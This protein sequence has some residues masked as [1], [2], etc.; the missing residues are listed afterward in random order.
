MKSFAAK[1]LFR[2]ALAM[3]TLGAVLFWNVDFLKIVFLGEHSTT[4]SLIL[5]G[6][7]LILFLSGMLKIVSALLHYRAQERQ[8]ELFLRIKEEGN[9]KALEELSHS[10][11][12]YRRYAKVKQLHERRTPI[13]H[14]AISSVT[15]AEE[16]LYVSYPRFV[17]NIL[18][19]TGVFGTIISLI[20]ALAGASS[21]LKTSVAGQGMWMI[22]NGMNTA[23]TTTG[24][25]IVC[26]FFFTYFYQKLLDAQTLLFSRIEDVTLTHIVPEFSFDAETVNYKIENMVTRVMELLKAFGESAQME[27]RAPMELAEI[28]ERLMRLDEMVELGRRQ[29]ELTAAMIE[30]SE[31]LHKTMRRGFR[32]ED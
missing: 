19:L 31:E 3:A 27:Q 32:L 28:K 17:N 20:L 15:L 8:T 7:I 26:Y 12:I 21:V 23:L 2:L 9:I 18:I 24:A 10:S 1:I 13:S 16:S 30:K 29:A 25:A 4:L 22:I 6:F 5:N 11:L 14:G